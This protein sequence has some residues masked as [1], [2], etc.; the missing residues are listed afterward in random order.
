MTGQKTSHAILAKARAMYGKRITTTQYEEL[1]RCRTV[2]E[3][4]GFLKGSTHFSQALSSVA[5]TTV[6]RGQL[7]SLLRRYAFEEYHKL[8]RY[9]IGHNKD[10][11]HYF[12]VREE[13]VELL[14]MVLLLK[15]NS[16][17]NFILD[18]PG[19]LIHRT[20][21]DL[22]AIA[23]VESYQELIE[24]LGEGEYAKILRRFL[25]EAGQ[26]LNY[27]AIEHAFHEHL[28]QRLFKMIDNRYHGAEAKEFRALISAYI[29]L[30]N[31]THIY[32]GVVYLKM[33]QELLVQ[34]LHLHRFK[35][36]PAQLDGLCQA[37]TKEEFLQ[38]FYKTY[39]H[40]R[41]P[42]PETDYFEHYTDGIFHRICQ[43]ALHFTTSS[44][45]AF[46]A[47]WNLHRN[48][49]KNIVSVIEGIRYNVED[50]EIRQLLIL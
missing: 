20:H 21:I 28:Y 4:A 31:L 43:H 7:E 19:H 32:R 9:N 1:L 26:P 33:P 5:E 14:R 25:P 13:I 11:I 36:T 46:Y 12:V 24:V 10:L 35:L 29:E 37:T 44:E 45:I 18:L 48:E 34:S 30:H 15:A 50:N 17:K 2:G 41:Y 39:Y 38:V 47:Y 23:K 6:H 22:I 8:Y 3:V 40:R 49:Q 42:L 27:V 16:Q